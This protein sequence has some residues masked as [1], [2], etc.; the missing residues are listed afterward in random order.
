MSAQL[1]RV[2]SR[3]RPAIPDGF[4]VDEAMVR[5]AYRCLGTQ[6]TILVTDSVA[7]A[8][9]GDG[10]YR[11]GGRAVHLREGVVRDDDGRL[12]GSALTVADAAARWL[13]MVP[14]SGPW[15]LS[16]LLAANPARLLGRADFGRIDVGQPARFGVLGANDRLACLHV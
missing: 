5:N 13:E 16:R 6:R 10:E 14:G 8:G 11:L 2:S 1:K 3:H 15:V 7:A 9:M 12:A 4:H